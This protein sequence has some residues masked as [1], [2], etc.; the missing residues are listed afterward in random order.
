MRYNGIADVPTTLR[1]EVVDMPRKWTPRNPD[2]LVLRYVGGESEQSLA[3]SCGVSRSAVGRFLTDM[4]VERRNRSQAMFTR[5]ANSSPAERRRLASA[6]HDAARGSHRTLQ[7][8]ERR[9]RGVE[10]RLGNVSES[11]RNLVAMMRRGG[12][13]VVQQKAVGP[14]NVDI[15]TGTVAV[16][17]FGGAWH[18]RKREGERLRYLLDHGWD[19]LYIWV[20]G[21]KYPLTRDAAQDAITFAEFRDRNPAAPRRYRVIRGG[22]QFVSAGSADRDDIPDVV[23]ISSRPEFAPASVP[24]G[25]CHCG[26]GRETPVATRTRRG[27]QVGEHLWFISGHNN[28][29]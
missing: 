23:P 13:S 10:Q 6:A 3:E 5:M 18:R 11:E 28:T 14:Y 2:D 9:A 19:V 15:A 17:I 27:H 25:T 22:G 12:R 1:I 24:Y 4:G 16:E 7:Q 26:C 20:D 29:R 8:L 21:I